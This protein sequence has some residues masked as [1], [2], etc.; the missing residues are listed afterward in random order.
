MAT[1]QGKKR[2]GFDKQNKIFASAAHFFAHFFAVTAGP[3][4]MSV[5]SGSLMQR[6]SYGGRKHTTF[7]SPSKLGFGS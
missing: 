7:L 1:K 5:E 4:A 2:N 3:H 6:F